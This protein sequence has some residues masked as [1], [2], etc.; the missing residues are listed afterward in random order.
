MLLDMIRN[1]FSVDTVISLCVRIF[2]IFCILPIHEFAHAFAAHKLGDETA[3]LSGRLTIS[4]LAHIDP[5]GAI[6]MIVAGV[7][8]AKPVPVNMNNL[9]TKNKKLGMAVVSFAGPF[10]NILMALFFMLVMNAVTKF[11]PS[12]DLTQIIFT[13]LYTAASLNVTLAVFN[14]IPIPPLDGSRLITLL[15]PDKYYYKIMQYERYIGIAF[16]L[17]ILFGALDV[18][19]A[20]LSSWLFKGLYYAAAFPFKFF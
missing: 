18:P 12:T 15:I 16:M 7:G 5:F 6:L 20:Y 4:P 17:I 8:W 9:K 13:F 10:S 11:A 19:L 14:L 2:V 3:R 1:G